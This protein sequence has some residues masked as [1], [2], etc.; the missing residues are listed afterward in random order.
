MIKSV[1]SVRHRIVIPLKKTVIFVFVFI[2]VFF[3]AALVTVF[4]TK[5]SYDRFMT[6]A[7]DYISSHQ[8]AS[9]LHEGSDYLTEQL[10][11]F[12]YTEDIEFL[13]NYYRELKVTKSRESALRIIQ[14]YELGENFVKSMENVLKISE[15]LSLYERY[16]IKLMVSALLEEGK[17][18]PVPE[19]IRKM[20]IPE[21]DQKL[22]SVMKKKKAKEMV[23]DSYYI[24]C[25]TDIETS[26]HSALTDL[27]IDADSRSVS[28]RKSLQKMA[29][30][31][32][33]VLVAMLLLSMLMVSVVMYS[34]I[35]PLN[36][37]LRNI[38]E[39]KPLDYVGAKEFKYFSS[40]YNDLWNAY[41]QNEINLKHEAEHDPLTGLI[42]R[43]Y[44][45]HLRHALEYSE[46]PVVLMIIDVDEFKNV[47]DRYGHEVGDAVL[48]R[49]SNILSEYF[50]TTDFVA[51]IGGDE[52]AIILTKFGADIKNSISV[53]LENIKA[54][55][56]ESTSEIPGS[57]ISVGIAMSERGFPEN[58]F[59]QADK[60]LYRV[61]LNGRNAYAF[62][63][64]S[65]DRD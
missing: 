62:Y 11:L 26:R 2:A 55:L 42:N 15:K 1:E 64:E 30:I 56:A 18:F 29:G 50:R 63:D 40:V 43:R 53:K 20:R 35:R 32:L 6:T 16:A 49:V 57:T 3:V 23:F 22:S 51:R 31:T 54:A 41:L 59:Q 19:E 27:M 4:L 58:L 8:A 24:S 9:S 37:Y 13:D 61:K 5:K 21:N 7:E 45:S 52:F 10:R 34:V 12:V 28:D 65:L 33:S 46:A 48:V 60:A 25:K 44:F 39:R 36:H 14:K 47:N 17:E 38:Q